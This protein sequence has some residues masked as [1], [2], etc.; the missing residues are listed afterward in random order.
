MRGFWRGEITLRKLRVLLEGLPQD[1]PTRWH[2]TDGHPW[3]DSHQMQWQA[4]WAMATAASALARPGRGKSVFD[5]MPRFPWESPEG[6]PKKFGSLDGVNQEDVLDYL[7][8]L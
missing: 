6:G 8:N 7:D 5:K 3:T 1:A 4:L 2:A